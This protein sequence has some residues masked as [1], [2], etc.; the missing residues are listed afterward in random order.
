MSAHQGYSF[1]VGNACKQL[2]QPP[3]FQLAHTSRTTTV[4][5]IRI[6]RTQSGGVKSLD[7]GWDVG[8]H[9]KG[10]VAGC[11]RRSLLKATPHRVGFSTHWRP[12]CCLRDKD[13][14]IMLFPELSIQAVVV[15]RCRHMCGC[16]TT[17]ISMFCGGGR[18]PLGVDDCMQLH[19]AARLISCLTHLSYHGIFRQTRCRSVKYCYR[20]SSV[21]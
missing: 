18:L 9:F 19:G 2:Q 4:M 7:K 21:S 5:P 20:I 1:L 6:T 14:G 3:I 8:L 13:L 15:G 12:A 16:N 17:L 11:S 10:F